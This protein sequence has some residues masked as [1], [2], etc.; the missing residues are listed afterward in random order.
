MKSH[1]SDPLRRL[2]MLAWPYAGQMLLAALTSLLTVGSSVGLLAAGAWIIS[3]ASLQPSIAVLHVAIAGVRFFGVARGVFRYLERLVS[4]RVSLSLL[5]HLRTWFYATVEPLAP[6]RLE[7]YHSGDLLARIVSD[8]ETLQEFYVRVIAPPLVA[9]LTGIGM[10]VFTALHDLRITAVLISFYVLGGLVLPLGIARLSREHGRKFIE[11]RARLNSA[12]VE[13]VQGLPDLTAYGAA[14]RHAEHIRALSLD[15]R[16]A[17]YRA[18]RIEGLE[19]GLGLFSVSAAMLAVLVIAIPHVPGVSLASITLGVVASFE[20]VLPLAFAARQIDSSR[21]AAQR[22]Y[23]IVDA[24]PAVVDRPS[25]PPTLTRYDLQI[26]G[27][28]FRYAPTAPPALRDI[29]LH[30]EEGQRVAILGSSG[31]GKTTLLNLLLRFWEF[32]EGYIRLGGHDLRTLRQDDVRA[33]IGVVTQTTRLFNTSLRENLLIARPDASEAQL[34]DAARRAHVHDLVSS[35]PDGY[36][37]LAGEQGTRF[38]GGERQRI[39]LARVLLKDA[40]LLFLDEPT[41][42]LDAVSEAAV[43]Q[44]LL[45]AGAGR[46]TLLITHRP[47]GVNRMDY[48]YVLQDGQIVDQGTPQQLAGRPGL[49]ARMLA[50]MTPGSPT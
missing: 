44:S 25:L 11:T 10:A 31:A 12:L 35:L 6:A 36:D 18:G 41:A 1:H 3:M 14:Q 21:A 7:G 33:L 29:T 47:A 23:E 2:G 34:I 42:N 17:Q 46:S 30:V 38:S 19:T 27:L 40:P 50:S 43:M 4:H 20:A 49:Y 32:T 8:I 24:A 37:T 16:A 9:I 45:E 26:E 39:A 22:L 48:I 28:T 15:L 13:G 5:A